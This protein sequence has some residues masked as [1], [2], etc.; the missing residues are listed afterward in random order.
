VARSLRLKI[1]LLGA[2]IV[3]AYLAEAFLSYAQAPQ[4]WREEGPRLMAF[5]EDFLGDRQASWLHMML[6]T[7][8][9]II[10]S[11]WAPL[12]AASLAALALVLMLLRRREAL[13]ESVARLLFRWPIAFAAACFF[14]FPVFTQDLWLSAVW[15]RMIAAGINPY[16][17]LFTAPFLAGLPLDHFPMPMS[18]APLW[19]LGSAAVTLVAAND[20]I[21]IGLV[22][23]A[24]LAAGWIA[25]LWL[26]ARI[27][28]ARPP[29]E[30][31]LALAAFGWVPLSVTQTVAEGHNDIAMIALALLWMLLLL[32]GRAAA[33]V[34]LAASVLA[35]YVTAPLFVLDLLYALRAQRIGWRRY[36][37]RMIA[38]ALLGLG[39]IAL[40]FRSEDFFDGLRM[41]NEWRFLRPRD[42]LAALELALGLS[43][44]PVSY[45]LIAL[46]PAIA[47]HRLVVF[48]REPAAEHL[49]KAALAIMAALL[50]SASAHVWPWYLL[51]VLAPAALVPGWW[52][53]RFAIGVAVMAPFMSGSWW[54]APFEDHFGGSA[55]VL[56]GGAVVW[57]VLTRP[58]AP[59]QDPAPAPK[60][61]SSF[62]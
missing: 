22:S 10:A 33:P 17:T 38:P 12:G 48:W 9:R 39:V 50:F 19:G 58:R 5:F 16:E 20:A 41:V 26:V 47:L 37:L 53:A 43:L 2:V 46:F 27:T 60:P 35:K 59:A 51:W 34:A 25:G 45:L 21:A 62:P 40:F 15:G 24:L 4:L 28:A 1:N 32:R 31:C 8:E 55:L 42:A 57:A 13:D 52:L 11:Y 54:V 44:T 18:Y 56:Y 36:L 29:A 3:L 6:F 14:T 61:G 49:Q 7:K 30:R 23:K